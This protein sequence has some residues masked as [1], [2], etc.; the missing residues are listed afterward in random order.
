MSQLVVRCDDSNL[1]EATLVQLVLALLG[2]D[3]LLVGELSDLHL[4]LEA[5]DKVA[6]ARLFYAR[7]GCHGCCSLIRKFVYYRKQ[8]VHSMGRSHVLFSCEREKG[9]FFAAGRLVGL[10]EFWLLVD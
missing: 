2:G 6:K 7:V 1:G 4:A 3:Q 8:R 9:R 10:L 5:L